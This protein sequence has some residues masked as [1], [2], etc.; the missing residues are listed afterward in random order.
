MEK[1]PQ[2][3][4]RLAAERND[5]NW[6]FRT[7]LK[8][9][10]RVKHSRV[11]AAARQFGEA[12]R[13]QMD[14]TTCGACCR[15][16]AIPVDDDDIKRLA[17]HLKSS[18]SA[19]RKQYVESDEFCDN[20][21][22]TSPCPFLEGNLC[23]VYPHRPQACREYPYIGGNISTRMIGIIERAENCPIVY[24]MLEQLKKHLGFYRYR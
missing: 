16:N 4:S 2:A 20:Y 19:F 8:M 14:C 24:E 7:F 23:T 22:E 18:V 11:D 5:E 1:D 6:S 13:D 12:A 10:G 17:R 9:S 21:I 15:V 3:V